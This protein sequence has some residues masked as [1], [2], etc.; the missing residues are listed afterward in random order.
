M[1]IGVIGKGNVGG[2]LARLWEQKGHEVVT[3]GSD[4]DA[5]RSAVEHG[6]VILI[7]TP[8]GT[9]AGV[10]AELGLDGK[11][12]IDATNRFESGLAGSLAEDV[13]QAAPGA[14]VVKAF[15]SVFAATYDGIQG[16]AQTPHVYIA[17]DDAGAKEQV[18]ELARDAGFEAVDVGGLEK[19]AD[20]EGFARANIAVAYAQ[21]K[22]P[23]VYR[24]FM[25][26]ELQAG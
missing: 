11:T 21:G 25:P 24:L 8:P 13:A 12:V 10:A 1:K 6:D 7:A 15:N 17:G 9:A 16:A 18:T 26:E 23:F 5:K 4:M 2:G 14:N 20:L 19:A 3:S 22:G